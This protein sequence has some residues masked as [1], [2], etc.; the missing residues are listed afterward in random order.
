MSAEH[1]IITTAD[2][3]DQFDSPVMRAMLAAQDRGRIAIL[4]E[5]GPATLEGF[6]I[7]IDTLRAECKMIA[8]YRLCIE[9]RE[10]FGGG[11]ST[12]HMTVNAPKG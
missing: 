5:N 11:S 3:T 2:W 8:T 10:F 4:K 12:H 1:H 9:R 6:N 7:H